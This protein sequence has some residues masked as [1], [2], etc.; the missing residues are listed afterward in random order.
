MCVFADI[1]DTEWIVIV[2]VLVIVLVVLIITVAKCLEIGR[3]VSDKSLLKVGHDYCMF[4]PRT[5]VA[6]M[7]TV[8]FTREAL[9]NIITRF[10]T[11]HCIFGV[12]VDSFTW[13]G[14]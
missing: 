8:S 12:N 13:E 6:R 2:L 11:E 3:D 10:S 14:T 9:N 7:P 5:H 4:A 1:S